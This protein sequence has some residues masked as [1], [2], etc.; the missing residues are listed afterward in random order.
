MEK[1]SQITN[2]IVTDYLNRFYSPLNPQMMNLRLSAE[3]DGIPIIL[4]ETE[5]FLAVLLSIIHPER[6]L[7]I[8]TGSGCIILSLLKYSNSCQGTATDLSAGALSVAK[9]N[10]ERLGLTVRLVHT[11]L[12][13]GL[14]GPSDIIVSNPPYIAR[15]VIPT[16]MPEVKDH[17]PVSALDGGEDGLDFYRRILQETAPLLAKEGRYY[18]EIGYDQ[19]AAVKGLLEQYG[20]QPAKVIQDYAGLDRVVC[21]CRPACYI[22]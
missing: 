21:G 18:F 5:S 11:D 19:G 16:L 9:K 17:E 22:T 20:Y 6:I 2:P 10:A 12:A 1:T 15:D 13:E 8:G 3:Q 14:D 4:R 7:E